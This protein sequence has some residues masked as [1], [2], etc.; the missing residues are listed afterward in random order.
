MSG[1]LLALL[2]WYRSALLPRH[3]LAFFLRVIVTLLLR[4]ILTSLMS[5]HAALLSGHILALLPRYLSWFHTALLRR[6]IATLLAG[7]V[8]TLFPWY[9]EAGLPWDSLTVWPHDNITLCNRYLLTIL[10]G[11]PLLLRLALHT[12][13][14]PALL[15]RYSI[16]L[17]LLYITAHLSWDIPTLL[18][19]GAFTLLHGN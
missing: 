4:N 6:N 2:F 12:G 14:I 10:S 16:A 19:L 15:S 11:N 8:A 13:N 1:Y 3:T 5:I 9:I 7:V 17:F 18:I